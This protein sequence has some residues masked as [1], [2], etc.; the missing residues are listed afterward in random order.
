MRGFIFSDVKCFSD[1]VLINEIDVRHADSPIPS[2]I[3]HHKKN[4]K[5][6]RIPLVLIFHQHNLSVMFKHF[7]FIPQRDRVTAKI[8]YSLPTFHTDEIG[9]YQFPS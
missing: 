4:E 3:K 9:H 5:E 8:F 6:E 2:T 1:S 7:T